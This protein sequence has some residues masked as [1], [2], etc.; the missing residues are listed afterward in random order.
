M[1]VERIEV[2]ITPAMVEDAAMILA[3]IGLVENG[4]SEK[5]MRAAY[6]MLEAGLNGSTRVQP[7]RR[8]MGS[9]H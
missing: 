7:A 9:A 1:G 5:A 8:Q 6:L 4:Y 2:E 3:K